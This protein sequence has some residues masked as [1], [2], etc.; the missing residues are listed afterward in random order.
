[1]QQFV[2]NFEKLDF[3]LILFIIFVLSFAA[4]QQNNIFTENNFIKN[5]WEFDNFVLHQKTNSSFQLHDFKN[6]TTK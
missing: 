4:F 1:M 5:K 3:S 6:K 2:T